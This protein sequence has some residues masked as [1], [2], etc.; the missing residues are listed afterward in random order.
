LAWDQ[1]RFADAIEYHRSSIA[2][3]QS[4]DMP[5]SLAYA[6]LGMGDNE[7]MLGNF[8]SA[9]DYYQ[10]CIRLA[11]GIGHR[12]LVAASLKSLGLLASKQG[13]YE[14]ARVYGIEALGIFRELG[15]R[16]HTAFA[17][18][19]LGNVAQYFGEYNLALTY[20]GEC[21]QTFYEVGYK[22]PTFYALE[23]IV[24][25]LI[26]VDQHREVAVRFLGAAEVLRNETGLA[27]AP[28]FLEKYERMTVTLRQQLGDTLYATLWQEG[29]A[30]P[31][32]QIVTEA[33]QLSLAER[34]SSSLC[35]SE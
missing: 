4:L 29:E 33:L 7:R 15:D 30:T 16:I 19:H 20:F 5:L 32:A 6:S 23:D 27:V 22:W 14:Q 17:L 1:D 21:L 18:S 34:D 11:R 10:E 13:D 8:D 3:Y 26:V 35:S 25:L 2:I 31:L 12:G 28:N 24:E 9:C